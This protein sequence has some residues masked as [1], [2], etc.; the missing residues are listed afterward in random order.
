MSVRP[1]EPQVQNTR[2]EPIP[3]SYPSRVS[4][5]RLDAVLTIYR[6]SLSWV[7]HIWLTFSRKKESHNSIPANDERH[8]SANR[9]ADGL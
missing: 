3:H 1:Q 4:Q 8:Q 7:L 2:G 6:Y 5:T 9:D